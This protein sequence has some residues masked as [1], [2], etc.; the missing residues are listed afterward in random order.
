MSECTSCKLGLDAVV[1]G[2]AIAA[3]QEGCRHLSRRVSFGRPIIEDKLLREEHDKFSSF[4][5]VY[6]RV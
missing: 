3:T 1:K 5:G 4:P 2:R 6:I